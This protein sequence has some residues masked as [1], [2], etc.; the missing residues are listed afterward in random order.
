MDAYVPQ[1]KGVAGLIARLTVLASMML[2]ASGVLADEGGR[3]TDPE[4]GRFDASE[5]LLKYQGVLPVPIIITEPA[6]G[7]G[8]GVAAV[9]FDESIADASQHS[10]AETGRRAPPNISAFGGFKTENGTYGGFAGHMH[11]WDGDR[12]RYLGGVA[13]LA[14]NLDYYGRQGNAQRYTVDGLGLVQQ[15]LMRA[16]DT[17]WLFGLRYAYFDSEM[18]FDRERPLDLLDQTFKQRL[19]AVGALI[20]YDTR[21]NF[22]SPNAGSYVEGEGN[23]MR[24]EFGSTNS[25]DLLGARAYH[26]QPLSKS[27][28][29]GLRGDWQLAQGQVPFWAQPY[30]KLRGIPAARYQDRQA[31][32]GE[33]ELRFA[34]D[35]RWSVIGFGGMG[36]A[37]GGRN[38]FAEA[39]R[40]TSWGGGFRY[41]IARKLGLLA[42]L[43]IA[44]G[45]DDT[46]FYIQVGSAWR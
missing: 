14:I 2:A 7:Y 32:A 42:G 22:L 39:E 16:G 15:V 41:L 26:W 46:A 4:D 27:L 12:I 9:Y 11:S 25:F 10:M 23:F 17:P 34:L 44:R 21:D 43:D 35:E 29:L 28:V 38:D 30:V 5:H 3:F 1:R 13:K 36:K 20:D 19:G 33:L 31:A 45:P 37:Y 40:V 6:V 18:H 24:P 8:A